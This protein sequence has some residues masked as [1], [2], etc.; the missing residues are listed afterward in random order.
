[1][2]TERLEEEAAIALRRIARAV[3]RYSH[4][5]LMRSG[6]TLPQLA[7]LREVERRGQVSA[8]QLARA[9]HLSQPTVTGI[10]D[11]LVRRGLVERARGDSDRRT[12]WVAVTRK[13]RTALEAA[14]SLLQDRFLHELRSLDVGQQE[15]L[16]KTLQRIADMMDS[17]ESGPAP[18]EVLMGLPAVANSDAGP[19][20]PPRESVGAAQGGEAERGMA[21]ETGDSLR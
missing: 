3:D 18:V 15:V 20:E 12:V 13:G 9:L 7:A 4:R 16:V 6:L 8:S 19:Q 5:L 11:R 10:V 14:P 1:M 21:A 17:P 2:A